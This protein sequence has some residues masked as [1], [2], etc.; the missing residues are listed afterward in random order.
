MSIVRHSIGYIAKPN[1]NI[2]PERKSLIHAHHLAMLSGLNMA[3]IKHYLKLAGG[4]DNDLEHVTIDFNDKSK[5]VVINTFGISELLLAT[6]ELI[7]IHKQDNLFKYQFDVGDLVTSISIWGSNTPHQVVEKINDDEYKLVDFS[8]STQHAHHAKYHTELA[9]TL[10]PYISV[11]EM[12]LSTLV[13]LSD[14][15]QLSLDNFSRRTWFSTVNDLLSETSR[16]KQFYLDATNELHL[17]VVG[18]LKE[19]NIRLDLYKPEY[20]HE[21][22][23]ELSMSDF[24]NFNSPRFTPASFAASPVAE[25]KNGLRNSGYAA[26]I[27]PNGNFSKNIKSF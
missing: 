8:V 4:T 19:Y 20:L 22:M 13:D 5:P 18:K 15:P 10:T 23:A 11:H 21:V 26:S 3:T 12:N 24:N 7:S 1:V 14:K 16:N 25:F 17:L 9:S 2:D 6:Q 27:E